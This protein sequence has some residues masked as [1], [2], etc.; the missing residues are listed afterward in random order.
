MLVFINQIL[1]KERVNH[2]MLVHGVIQKAVRLRPI[3]RSAKKEHIRQLLV[4]HQY[5]RATIAHQVK[6]VKCLV[7][8]IVTFVF[9]AKSEQQLN[10]LVLVS[11]PIAYVENLHLREVKHRVQN[12]LLGNTALTSTL[13]QLQ[14]MVA[15]NVQ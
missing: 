4:H 14:L 5:Q 10:L 11:V 9:R 7:L 6:R 8:I 1:A 15:L 3:A 2:A 13:A 12:V